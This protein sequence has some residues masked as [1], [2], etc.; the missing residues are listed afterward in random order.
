MPLKIEISVKKYLKSSVH[1]LVAQMGGGPTCGK[2]KS[3]GRICICELDLQPWLRVVLVFENCVSP[4]HVPARV[5]SECVSC[6]LCGFNSVREGD[7][8]SL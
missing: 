2:E 1:E 3:L 7:L 4:S 5:S 6:R 8:R